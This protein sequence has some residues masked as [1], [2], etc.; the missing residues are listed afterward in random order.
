MF[1]GFLP[2]RSGARRNRMKKLV[3]LGCTVVFYESCHR[4]VATLEDIQQVF[5]ERRI[6]VTRELTKKFE[7]VKRASAKEII[8]DLRKNKPRGE[9]AVVI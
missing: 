7:E 9:F 3:Q 6:V 8:G 2:I 5:G 1:V 4:I